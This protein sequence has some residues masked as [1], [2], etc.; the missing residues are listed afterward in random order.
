MNVSK[1]KS[2]VGIEL[3]EQAKE[4]IEQ[5]VYLDTAQ[6]QDKSQF[7]EKLYELWRKGLST[8]AKAEKQFE[9][10]KDFIRET[11]LKS[12]P[13]NEREEIL[14]VAQIY[15]TIKYGLPYKTVDNSIIPSNTELV[16]KFQRKV[17]ANK[18][19]INNRFESLLNE[20]TEYIKNKIYNV[21]TSILVAPVEQQTLPSRGSLGRQAKDKALIEGYSGM[22]PSIHEGKRKRKNITGLNSEE[23][24]DSNEVNIICLCKNLEISIYILPLSKDTGDDEYGVPPRKKNDPKV[25]I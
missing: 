11:I 24:G 14:N 10:N 7:F 20:F 17:Y 25:T 2:I 23:S 6:R 13:A 16:R 18:R 5:L 1:T 3:T 8:G 22:V 19:K 15:E 4:L 9:A 21:P 12:F